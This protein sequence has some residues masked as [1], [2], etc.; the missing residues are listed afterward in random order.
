LKDQ[1]PIHDYEIKD[2]KGLSLRSKPAE[3]LSAL[4]KW[5]SLPDLQK[6]CLERGFI[7]SVHI[8]QIP[9]GMT[10]REILI[11]HFRKV[12]RKWW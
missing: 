8:V 1:L 11:E 10:V 9:G 4:N 3:N 2:F 12:V 7:E 5:L 6:A